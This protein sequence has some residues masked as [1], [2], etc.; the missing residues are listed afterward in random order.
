MGNTVGLPALP[1]GN[2]MT[3]N[4][5]LTRYGGTQPVDITGF[6][7]AFIANKDMDG[8]TLPPV[9][10]EWNMHTDPENG[11]TQFLIPDSLT[12][13][14]IPGTYFWNVTTRDPSGN[15]ETYAAGTWSIVPVPG[16]ISST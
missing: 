16:F 4:L 11:A 13:T 5:N 15:V 2:S 6:V 1:R 3:V 14:L 10:I 9:Y 8:K 12:R 7:F